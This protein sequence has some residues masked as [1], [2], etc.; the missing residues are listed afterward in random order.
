M[1]IFNDLGPGLVLSLQS[2][3]NNKCADQTVRMC[4]LAD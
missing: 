4:R 1:K 2:A 3:E